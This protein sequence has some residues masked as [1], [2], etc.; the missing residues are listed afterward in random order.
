MENKFEVVFCIV[1]AGFSEAVMD[2]A[3]NAGARGGT[4]LHARGTA[5]VEAEKL[6]GISVQPEKEIVMIIVDVRIK[7]DVLRNLYRD[8]GLQT[9]GQGIAFTMP[10]SQVVGLS[11]HAEHKQEQHHKAT[12][13]TEKNDGD[14]HPV[15]TSKASENK[16]AE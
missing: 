6:F 14:E 1:N 12:R 4:V 7:E 13:E 8:V 11:P 10:V 5:N 9:A 15:D 2:S 3:R 16:P